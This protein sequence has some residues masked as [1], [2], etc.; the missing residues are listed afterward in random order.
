VE[1]ALAG[2]GGGGSDFAA[3]EFATTFSHRDT[4]RGERFVVSPQTI[5]QAIFTTVETQL[6][7]DER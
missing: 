1:K 2:F 7:F 6:F 4:K 5:S 3:R